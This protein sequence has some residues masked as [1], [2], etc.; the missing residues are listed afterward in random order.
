V[1]KLK[2]NNRKREKGNEWCEM[3]KGE[4]TRKF[5][6]NCLERSHDGDDSSTEIV[7][8]KLNVELM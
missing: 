1:R 4:E 7:A 5:N 2:A 8:E 6:E 3:K